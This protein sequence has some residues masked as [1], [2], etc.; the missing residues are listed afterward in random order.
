[1]ISPTN[2]PTI[3]PMISPTICRTISPTTYPTICPMEIY[4]ILPTICPTFCTM[5]C[6]TL[7]HTIY[8]K[9]S[10]NLGYSHWHATCLPYLTYLPLSY[11]FWCTLKSDSII[12]FLAPE[13]HK[14]YT[15]IVILSLR[16]LELLTFKCQI[17]AIFTAILFFS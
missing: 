12:A 5:V 15:N 7:C 10:Y 13:Y 16:A 14:V 17:S 9:I 1:M 2:F 11:L 4:T 3:C 8:P 6:S